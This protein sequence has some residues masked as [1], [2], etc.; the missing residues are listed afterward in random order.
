[1]NDKK[2]AMETLCNVKET[3]ISLVK[4]EVSGNLSEVDTHELGEVVDMIKDIAETERNCMEAKYYETVTEAME[5]VDSER[6]GYNNRRY[7]SGRYAPKGMGHISG[8]NRPYLDQEPYVADYI[9]R[10]SEFMD[11]MRMGYTPMTTTHMEGPN[12]MD[13]RYGRSYN[14]FRNARKNYTRTNS[15][16]DKEE[17]NR[18]GHEHLNDTIVTLKDI[19]KNADPEL[20]KKMKS[21]LSSLVSEMSVS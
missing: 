16:E 17:M 10:P 14:E 8:Y 9:E 6:Y 21:D 3:L 13:S 20:K 11:R 12:N 15:S 19:W 18:T 4:S 7:S 1:M 2:Y 5:D